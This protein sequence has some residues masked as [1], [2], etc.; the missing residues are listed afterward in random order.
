MPLGAYLAFRT[1][2]AGMGLWLGLS[3]GLAVVAIM[4]VTRWTRRNAHP[5]SLAAPV[6]VHASE[7]VIA[8]KSVT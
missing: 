5:P 8:R 3:V 2:Y 4:L 1:D 7:G 6:E